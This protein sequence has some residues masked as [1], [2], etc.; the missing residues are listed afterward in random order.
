MV[1]NDKKLTILH[2]E[3]D[4]QL[5]KLVKV[6]FAGFGFRGEMLWASGVAEALDLL[7]RRGLN[8]ESVNLIL[9]DMQLPDGL[10]LDVIREVKSDPV[11]QSTPIIVLSSETSAS[12]INGAYAL[13]ANC[14]MPK[15]PRTNNALNSLK[16]L[17]SCWIEAAI[18]PEQQRRDHLQDALTRAVRLRARTSEFYLRLARVYDEDP[19]EM[20]FWLDR[21]LNEGNLTNLLAFFQNMIGEGDVSAETI[22]RVA[23]MQFQVRKALTTAEGLLSRKPSPTPAEACRWALDLMVVLDEEVVA[24]VLGSFFSKGPEATA[25]LKARAAAQLMDLANHIME[26]TEDVD[27]RQRA[28]DLVA[29]SERL[30]AGT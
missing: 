23:G 8:R 15:I 21:S 7:N 28:R 16:V 2:V 22:D 3:D 27:L 14:Y 11:W 13:G 17:Y 25:A 20:G 30:S 1:L 9:V 4:P 12:M 29:W 10:G 24:E 6:A 5:A 19:E 26:R 18:L